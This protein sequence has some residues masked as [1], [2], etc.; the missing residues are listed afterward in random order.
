MV[1]VKGNQIVMQDGFEVSS[2]PNWL[3][4]SPGALNDKRMSRAIPFVVTVKSDGL[5]SGHMN[6]KNV[7]QSLRNRKQVVVPVTMW[8]P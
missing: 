3:R 1:F 2:T 8:V 6:G 7:F 5:A 4:V